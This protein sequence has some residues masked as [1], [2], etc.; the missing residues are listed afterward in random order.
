MN[1]R[2]HPNAVLNFQS[3]TRVRASHTALRAKKAA[4]PSTQ[5]RRSVRANLEPAHAKSRRWG[6]GLRILA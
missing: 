2:D 4:R 3:F 5:V 6:P 1:G